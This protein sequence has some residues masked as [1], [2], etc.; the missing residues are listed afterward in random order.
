MKPPEFE[1]VQAFLPALKANPIW[2]A[3]IIFF[4]GG[5]ALMALLIHRN[6]RFGFRDTALDTMGFKRFERTV[7]INITQAVTLVGAMCL[8]IWA[9]AAG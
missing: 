9:A 3:A 4:S 1:L 5:V 2:G 8:M 6:N 7:A